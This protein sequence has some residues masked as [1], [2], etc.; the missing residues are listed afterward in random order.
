MNLGVDHFVLWTKDWTK[1]LDTW[2]SLFKW[3]LLRILQQQNYWVNY[4]VK[5]SLLPTLSEHFMVALQS[6]QYTRTGSLM[7]SASHEPIWL[8]RNLNVEYL[9]WFFYTWLFNWAFLICWEVKKYSI[10]KL[11]HKRISRWHAED[12]R[13]YKLKMPRHAN[14]KTVSFYCNFY[15]YAPC[16]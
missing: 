7:S 8:W 14:F 5:K 4:V 16:A 13:N 12:I 11:C 6:A 3:D 1:I 9:F 15:K 2:T 10:F